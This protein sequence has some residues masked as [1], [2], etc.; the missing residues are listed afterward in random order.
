MVIHHIV[1]SVKNLKRS[2]KFYEAFLGK[3]TVSKYDA[4]WR[5]GDTMLFLVPPYKKFSR[6]FDKH[7]LGLNHVAFQVRSLNE[8]EKYERAL[9]KARIKNSGIQVDKYGKKPFIWFDDPDKIR[10]E[11]YLK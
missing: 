1:I 8:L 9:N 5:L 7:N 3:P 10:L 4:H 11:L 6:R 2:I